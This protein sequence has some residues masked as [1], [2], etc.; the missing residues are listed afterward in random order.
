MQEY[1]IVIHTRTLSHNEIECTEEWKRERNRQ[2]G[3][4]EQINDVHQFF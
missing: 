2:I 1:E 3:E 4:L